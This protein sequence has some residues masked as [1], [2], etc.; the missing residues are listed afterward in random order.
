MQTKRKVQLFID[1]KREGQYFELPFDVPE[2]VSRIDV[3]YSYP[4]HVETVKDG[5]T[6]CIE[7]NIIDL[8]LKNSDGRFIGASG[9]DRNHVWIT[10]Y[11]SSLG[12]AETE[13]KKGRW[14]VIVGAYK[15]MDEGVTVEYEF[16]F[17]HKERTLLKGDLHMHSL[18]S[19]GI[20]SVDEITDLAKKT[21][22]QFI[23]ITDHNN[24]FHNRLLK[25]DADITVMPGVE[26][27]HYKGHVNMLGVREPYDGDYYTNSL[28][29][30]RELIKSARRKG[31]I[32][33][34]N[35]PFCPNC[36][37]RW[38]L[39][40][41]EYDCIEIWNGPMKKAEVD[42]IRWWHDQLCAGKRIPVVGGSDFHRFEPGRAIGMPTT[43][44]YAMS[45][46]P[47][48]IYAAILEGNGYVTCHPDGPGVFIECDGKIM[49]QA[50]EYKPNL[51]I[52]F[53]FSRLRKGDI[54]KII[55]N[56][57]EESIT[58][59]SDKQQVVV[60]RSVGNAMFYRAEV[61]RRYEEGFPCMP[62]MISNPVYIKNHGDATH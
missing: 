1:K 56:N 4:R 43:C 21:G 31:A 26:W 25:S 37:F 3:R 58:C 16:T 8:A 11:N 55:S 47:S 34:I 14:A 46:A 38:G 36:A 35:H 32:I 52:S 48:D 12:Y 20:L 61:H 54:I 10:E 27:T 5:E 45:R 18:G 17:T 33:S 51:K 60:E 53:T 13:I 62:V 29:E 49:G 2:N 9:S 22:L 23:F 39:E 44:L 57:R 6:E 24:Y 40:N 59:S 30:T 42:C 28:E 15:V 19:D 7:K 50:V 41:V